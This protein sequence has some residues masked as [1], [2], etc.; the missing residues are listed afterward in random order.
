MTKQEIF[1]FSKTVPYSYSLLK[2]LHAYLDAKY[3]M[4]DMK[5]KICHD[6]MTTARYPFDVAYDSGMYKKK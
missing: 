4:L 2:E 5:K 6:S 3:Q 1:A